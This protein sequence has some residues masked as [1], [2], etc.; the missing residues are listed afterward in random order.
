MSVVRIVIDDSL[1]RGLAA[2]AAAMVALTLGATMPELMGDDLVDADG[3]LHPGLVPQGVPVLRAP[4]DELGRLRAQ[5][6]EAGIEVIDF[7]TFGQQTTNYDEVIDRVAST[8]AAELEYLAIALR[9]PQRPV[10]KLT[11]SLPLLR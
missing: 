1:S 3:H 9:G 8:R 5:A 2:N 4:R 11:G 6:I 10:R 7:P